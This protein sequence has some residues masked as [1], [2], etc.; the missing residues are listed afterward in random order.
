MLVRN[1]FMVSI[2]ERGNSGY[3]LRASVGARLCTGFIADVTVNVR[4]CH[5]DVRGTAPH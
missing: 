1:E 5:S 3:S 2:R 4:G